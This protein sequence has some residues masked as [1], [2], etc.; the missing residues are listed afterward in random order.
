MTPHKLGMTY[1]VMNKTTSIL[2]VKD[3]IEKKT[4][5]D[6]INTEYISI[7]NII[8]KRSFN[9]MNLI[10]FNIII[11]LMTTCSLSYNLMFPR[12]FF[13]HLLVIY[14]YMRFFSDSIFL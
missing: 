11:S 6:F 9:P 1:S 3:N 5:I 4:S 14:V 12:M 8:N 10:Y 7:N 13:L 2:G